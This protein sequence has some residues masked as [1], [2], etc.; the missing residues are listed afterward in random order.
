MR[1]YLD[2]A[3]E[4]GYFDDP[5]ILYDLTPAEIAATIAGKAARDRQ[6]QQLENVRAG[7]VCAMIFNQHRRKR[8]DK[9]LTWKDFF[10][11]TTVKP[12]QSPE[13]MK[14]RCRDITLIFGGTV[15]TH[16]VERREPDRDAGP[17]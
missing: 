1:E 17:G 5:R 8:S 12:A 14:Q 9:A 4:T 10:P 3:A 13:E 11:D 2:L 16:G 15:T 7:T 6:Q